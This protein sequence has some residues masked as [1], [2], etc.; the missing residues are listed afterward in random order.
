MQ[1]RLVQV[2]RRQLEQ[3]LE[4]VQRR[5]LS[6]ERQWLELELQSKLVLVPV[7]LLVALWRPVLLELVPVSIELLR[8]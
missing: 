2:Q 4:L 3:R 1:Q 8:S 5:Q 7:L 6:M